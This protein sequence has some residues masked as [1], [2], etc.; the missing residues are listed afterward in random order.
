MGKI[1]GDFYPWNEENA[2]NIPAKSGA[3][4]LYESRTE[5][6]LIYIGSTSNLRER[7]THYWDTNF[8]EDPCKRSTRF[9]KRE[10]TNAYETRERELLE[11][12][13]R[14]HDGRLPRCNERVP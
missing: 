2:K 8:S 1:D 7:F 6:G 5:N 3:Y 14:E 13:R 10:I 9:Y 4:G 11:Q 12:Y